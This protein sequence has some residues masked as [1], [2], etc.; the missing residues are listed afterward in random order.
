MGEEGR[1][2]RETINNICSE[3]EQTAKRAARLNGLK[4]RG[5]KLNIE[6]AIAKHDSNFPLGIYL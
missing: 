4:H 6:M 3:D 2:K 1:K 5:R